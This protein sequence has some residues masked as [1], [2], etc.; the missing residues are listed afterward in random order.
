MDIY[1]FCLYLGFTGMVSML[2]LGIL[3][4]LGG[5]GHGH[6]GGAHTNGHGGFHGHGGGTHGGAHTGTHDIGHPATHVHADELLVHGSH[7][8]GTH[9]HAGG[10]AHASGHAHGRSSP[11]RSLLAL[12]SPRVLFSL[13]LGFGATGILLKAAEPPFIAM[14]APYATLIG[15]PGMIA[16][17]GRFALAVGGGWGFE[18]LIVSPLWDF[19]FRFASPAH[20]LE[21]ALC[22]DARAVTNFDESGHGLIAIDL[23][24]QVVQVLGKLT[25]GARAAGVRVRAGDSLF[26]EAVDAQRNTCTVSLH[27]S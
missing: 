12:L 25:P 23:D 1:R 27:G 6:S 18:H 19:M 14:L 15:D 21:S 4:H 8:H 17:G 10:N 13:L 16:R 24:G 3:G 26:V 7:G 11:G 22:E 9:A 20:T 2:L 5:I